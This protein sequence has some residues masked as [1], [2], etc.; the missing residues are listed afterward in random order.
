MSAWPSNARWMAPAPVFWS[1]FPSTKC[2]PRGPSPIRPCLQ[3]EHG[4]KPSGQDMNWPSWVM[5]RGSGAKPA[6]AAL[7]ELARRVAR[8]RAEGLEI[9]TLV[10]K[11]VL[12]ID[13]S[14][15][16]IK[17]GIV[18][19]RH[20]V[21]P[22]MMHSPRRL[23]PQTLRYG[24]WGFPVSITLPGT[25]RWLPGG[26]GT[27]AAR[28]EID[29]AISERGT[30]HLAV[31]APRLVERGGSAVRVVERRVGTCR[32]PSPARI[33]AS[34]HT[35]RGGAGPGSRESRPAVAVDL[36]SRGLARRPDH[37]SCES[38]CGWCSWTT[39]AEPA[40]QANSR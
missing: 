34:G 37:R 33:A 15:L 21:R 25:S 28:F 20:R 32:S 17:E 14:D 18:A 27:R 23:H 16:V 2:L 6:A 1:C 29:R 36:A 13:H 40:H 8:A 26:G 12:P 35:R 38:A 10:L 22:Q 7:R 3:P 4:S 31:D 19:A 9:H 30:L 5:P 39:A 11:S 24:L